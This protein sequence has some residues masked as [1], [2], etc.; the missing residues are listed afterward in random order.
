RQTEVLLHHIRHLAGTPQS[1]R[2]LLRRFTEQRDG[3]AFAALVERHGPMVLGL[4]RRVLQHTHDAEDAFQATFLLLARKA[5]SLR[6]QEAVGNWLYGAAYRVALKARTAARRRAAREGR[7]EQPITPPDPASE[8]TLR[9]ARTLL[10]EELARLPERLRA[11]LVLCCLEGATR[12]EAARHLGWPLGTLKRRLG[13]ARALLRV[14]LARRG[15]TLSSAL[16]AVLVEQGEAPAA[17]PAALRD[18]VVRAALP[19]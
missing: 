10:D 6:R 2:E 19:P 15:L 11:A 18:T 3:T 7:A 12:D 8:L 1:D 5:A 16:V 13:Q 4:C 9:E 14:R 17:V